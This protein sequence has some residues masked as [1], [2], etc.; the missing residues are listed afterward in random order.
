MDGNKTSATNGLIK[1]LPGKKVSVN[2]VY[3]RPL[4]SL[5]QG[6]EKCIDSSSPVHSDD[7]CDVTYSVKFI[8]PKKKSMY[9]VKKWRINRRF[10][11]VAKVQR[12]L[13]QTFDKDL[14]QT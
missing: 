12:E 3:V 2:N 10:Q 6:S 1:Y 14:L 5:L 11:S 8:N 4:F 13:K 7:E 9:F